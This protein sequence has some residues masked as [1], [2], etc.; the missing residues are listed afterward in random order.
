MEEPNTEGRM[1]KD[2]G[3]WYVD[4]CGSTMAHE[5][6]REGRSHMHRKTYIEAKEMKKEKAIQLRE[7]E[8][9]MTELSNDIVEMIADT[10]SDEKAYIEKK[11]TAL[12]T[13]IGSMK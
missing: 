9:Y 8:K 13:K 5:D 6:S 1:R 12:A 2:G 11:M 10:S 7:L 3:M 4:T